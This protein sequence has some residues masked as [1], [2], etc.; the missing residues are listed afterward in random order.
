[1]KGRREEEDRKGLLMIGKKEKRKRM[2]R[3]TK[4]AKKKMKGK[5]ERKKREKKIQYT[6]EETNTMR[7]LNIRIKK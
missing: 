6:N 7:S 2:I 3:K 1:M 4:C 5:K